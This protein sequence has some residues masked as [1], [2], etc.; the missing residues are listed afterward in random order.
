VIAVPKGY[1]DKVKSEFTAEPRLIAPIEAGRSSACSSHHRRQ[2]L[3]RISGLALEKVRSPAILRPHLGHHSTLVQ[4]KP[5]TP[6]VA[7]PVY[8]NGQFLPLAEAGISPLDRGFLY[9]DGVYELIPVY[10]RRP[11]GLTNT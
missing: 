9:G 5:M 6:Y 3:W 1:A 8:L 11:S 10:S 7:D 4:L 2:G